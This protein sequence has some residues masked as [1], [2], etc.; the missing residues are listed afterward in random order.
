MIAAY[1]KMPDS[2][3]WFYDFS[4]DCNSITVTNEEMSRVDV[5]ADANMSR[6]ALLSIL[7]PKQ[8]SSLDILLER[9]IS[10]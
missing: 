5:G 10:L 8:Y 1:E 7:T 2:N 4:A 6:D 9:L 3:H